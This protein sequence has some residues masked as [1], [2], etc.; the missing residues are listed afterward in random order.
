[1]G[2]ISRVSSRTYRF[3]QFFLPEKSKQDA[4]PPAR[5]VQQGPV[6]DPGQKVRP[7][8]PPQAGPVTLIGKIF[9]NHSLYPNGII[10]FKSK[11][12]TYS[13]FEF[14]GNMLLMVGPLLGLANLYR[15]TTDGSYFPK[16][17]QA[18]CGSWNNYY[19]HYKRFG[20]VP[21][22]ND[23]SYGSWNYYPKQ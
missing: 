10:R 16:Y 19:T 3:D 9:Y 14:S 12:C 13:K 22:L 4:R 15:L 11:A 18:G 23:R 20:I 7:G 2:L 5:P 21:D 1:M 6:P 17:L 8:S